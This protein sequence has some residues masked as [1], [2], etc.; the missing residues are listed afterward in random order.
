MKLLLG[1]FAGESFERWYF[2]LSW[3]RPA[4]THLGVTRKNGTFGEVDEP[5]FLSWFRETLSC[6][7]F[8]IGSTLIFR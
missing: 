4:L 7:F 8:A 5:R 2:G 1:L 6:G 3:S